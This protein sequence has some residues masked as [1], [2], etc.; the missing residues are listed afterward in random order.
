MIY[1]EGSRDNERGD[2]LSSTTQNDLV[3]YY[4]EVS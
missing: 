1:N 2:P 3:G 4:K